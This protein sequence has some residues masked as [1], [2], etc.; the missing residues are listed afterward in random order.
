MAAVSAS[1]I[2]NGIWSLRVYKDGDST[3]CRFFKAER[4]PDAQWRLSEADMTH[5]VCQTLRFA[6]IRAATIVAAGAPK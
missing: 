4:M 3:D 1:R 2:R 6:K 5:D